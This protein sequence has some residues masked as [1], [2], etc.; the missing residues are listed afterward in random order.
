MFQSQEVFE[1]HKAKLFALDRYFFIDQA[2][3]AHLA[4]DGGQ[5]ALEARFLQTCVP[6]SEVLLGLLFC[7]QK[8]KELRESDLYQFSN[9][10]AQGSIDGAHQLL[11]K[12]EQ[13]LAITLDGNATEFMQK[14][15][16]RIQHFV[17]HTEKGE[18]KYDDNG[19]LEQSTDLGAITSGADALKKIWQQIQDQQADALSLKILEPCVVYG[20][21]LSE[22]DRT[23]AHAKVQEVLKLSQSR[24]KN[25]A[26]KGA[27]AAKTSDAKGSKRK[28]AS[29][30]AE[31]AAAKAAKSLFG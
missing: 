9:A 5:A 23:K 15:F 13:G 1:T 10:G 8:S 7:V 26:P 11:N 20:H 14:V 2:F 25:R 12:I 28:A 16:A 6:S 31:D 21:F 19:K 24:S 30:Q 17:V 27:G 18:I 3:I 4:G 22:A 29:S